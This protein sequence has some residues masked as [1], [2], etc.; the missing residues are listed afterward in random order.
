M[1]ANGQTPDLLR[2]CS[3][4]IDVIASLLPYDDYVRAET[5]LGTVQAG[6]RRVEGLRSTYATDMVRTLRRAQAE[7]EVRC[8]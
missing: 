6:G 8:F 2:R 7:A 3:C 1:N 4:S 5:V